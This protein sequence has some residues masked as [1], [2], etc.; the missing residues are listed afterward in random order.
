MKWSA[1][2]GRSAT[3]LSFTYDGFNTPLK[4]APG[5]GWYYG[6]ATDWAGKV[7]ET[8]TGQPLGQYMAE[9]IFGPLGIHDTTFRPASLAE[10]TKGRTVACSYRDAETGLLSTGPQPTPVDPPVESGGAGLHS[11]AGDYVKVLQALLR[12]LSGD[13]GAACLVGRETVEEMLRPQLS[14]VQHGMLKQLTDMLRVAM[15]AEL[16]PGTPVD[17][18]IGGILNTA[19]VP[20]KRR[21][22]TMTWT[23]MC[24]GHWVSSTAR[25]NRPFFR[26]FVFVCGDG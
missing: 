8:V 15:V 18:G 24:N 17:H 26:P 16:P 21:K 4:F 6:T 9:N 1:A 20:G 23:G 7:L 22:G 13:G 25:P 3:T 14:E 11:T 10:R 5:E 12:A 19:D 2:V